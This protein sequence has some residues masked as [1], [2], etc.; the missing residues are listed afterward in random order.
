M[1]WRVCAV[2]R[3]NSLLQKPQRST[4][5][6]ESVDQRVSYPMQGYCQD[7]RQMLGQGKFLSAE[8]VLALEFDRA[9]V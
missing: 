7:F 9:F 6:S 2:C 4:R 1:Y 3:A 5:C 8:L